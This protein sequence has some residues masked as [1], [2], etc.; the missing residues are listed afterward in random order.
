MSLLRQRMLQDMKI[1][2]MSPRTQETY[3]SQVTKFA[4]HF[5]KSPELLGAH[6]IRH[7]QVYLVETGVSWSVFNQTVAALRFLYG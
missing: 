6:E 7:Y 4:R 5:K 1:R 2:N 3:L